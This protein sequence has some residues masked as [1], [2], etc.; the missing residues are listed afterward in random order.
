MGPRSPP[1]DRVASAHESVISATPSRPLSLPLAALAGFGLAG[2]LL[3]AVPPDAARAQAL[4]QAGDLDQNRFVLVAAPIGKGERSQLNIYEQ[5]RPTRACFAIGEGRPAAVNPLLATFDF[6]GICG[7]Y[8]DANGYSLRIGGTDLATSYRLTVSRSGNDTLLLAMPT[9]GSGPEM[10]V[11]RTGGVATG[12]L[13][14]ELEPGWSLKRRQFGGRSLGHVYVYR[15]GFPGAGAPSAAGAV[16]TAPAP[17]AV[18]P[19][20]PTTGRP[21]SATGG[22]PVPPAP[23]LLPATP[24]S[25]ASPSTPAASPTRRA[26]MR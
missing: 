14:F 18:P 6:T 1:Y 8:I 3:G 15:D 23:P 19:A 4:F 7:R 2:A 11:G 21:A 17:A 9:R 10:V 16:P 12:F 24:A 5:V 22:A 20:R 13:K 25:G 26:P